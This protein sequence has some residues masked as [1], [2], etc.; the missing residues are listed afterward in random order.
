MIGPPA[1]F[2]LERR[3]DYSGPGE[4]ATY[5][6]LVGDTNILTAE[7]FVRTDAILAAEF[8]RD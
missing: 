5:A 8:G 2:A 1:D 7:D 6:E 4:W 3:E